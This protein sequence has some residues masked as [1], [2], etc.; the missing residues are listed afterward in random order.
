M[1]QTGSVKARGENLRAAWAKFPT[2]S[3][4]VFVM[5]LIA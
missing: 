3:E 5:S 2:L 1:I 4:T